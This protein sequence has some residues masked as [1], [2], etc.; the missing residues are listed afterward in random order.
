MIQDIK[1]EIEFEIEIFIQKNKLQPENIGRGAIAPSSPLGISA[2]EYP[3]TE[4]QLHYF[5]L[6]LSL[7]AQVSEV[8]STD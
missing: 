3:L 1:F 2:Y 6:T 5:F 4:L 7:I 8:A